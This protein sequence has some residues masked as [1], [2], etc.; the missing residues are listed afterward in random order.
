MKR[1]VAFKIEC[2]DIPETEEEKLW[3]EKQNFANN[4]EEN[5]I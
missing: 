5:Y 4:A 3:L 2:I 1:S